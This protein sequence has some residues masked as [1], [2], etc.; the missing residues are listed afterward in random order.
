MSN[1]RMIVHRQILSVTEAKCYEKALLKM[2]IPCSETRFPPP[3]VF[4]TIGRACPKF[5]GDQTFSSLNNARTRQIGFQKVTLP[6]V[7]INVTVAV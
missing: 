7:V 2:G 1:F 6:R 3:R 4:E 5:L